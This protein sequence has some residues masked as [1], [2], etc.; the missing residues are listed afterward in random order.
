MGTRTPPKPD[1]TVAANP[2]LARQLAAGCRRYAELIEEQA[3][4]AAK[5]PSGE[6]SYDDTGRLTDHLVPNTSVLADLDSARE[7][8]SLFRQHAAELLARH[9]PG[10]SDG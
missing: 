10:A 3:E 6:P 7:H 1:T 4:G 2:F 8:A 9:A 5:V